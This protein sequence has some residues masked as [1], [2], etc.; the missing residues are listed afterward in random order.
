[1]RIDESCEDKTCECC[2]LWRAHNGMMRAEV[3]RLREQREEFRRKVEDMPNTII[4]RRA[5]RHVLAAL[6]GES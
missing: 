2:A 5:K 4:S 3:E 1:M 6:D